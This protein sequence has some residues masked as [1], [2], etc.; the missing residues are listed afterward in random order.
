[1]KSVTQRLL[2]TSTLLGVLN[3]VFGLLLASS[4]GREAPTA[5]FI[6]NPIIY[7]TIILVSVI[8]GAVCIYK[9]S[10]RFELLFIP[11][12][13]TSIYT[14]GSVISGLRGSLGISMPLEF[15]LVYL[16]WTFFQII[17]IYYYGTGKIE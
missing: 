4:V 13:S 14:F 10:P 1:M 11:C 5:S 15:Y 9:K 8:S 17:L 2:Q 3:M 7:N 16:S 6:E 12:V